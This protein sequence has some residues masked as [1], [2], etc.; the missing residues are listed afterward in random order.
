MLY[1]MM[2]RSGTKLMQWGWILMVGGFKYEVHRSVNG[3]G[4]E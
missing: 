2:L 1:I 3:L 4:Q